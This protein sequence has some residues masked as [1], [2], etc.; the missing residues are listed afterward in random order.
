[1]KFLAIG[2]I[3]FYQRVIS[4]LTP[5]T[6]RFAPTCSQYGLIAISRYGFWKGGWL[7]AKRIAKC[8]PFHPGGYDPVP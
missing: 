6:C 7:T 3:R 5:P 1:M 8:H 4:P 2:L